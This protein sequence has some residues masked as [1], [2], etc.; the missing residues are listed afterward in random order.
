MKTLL[1][2]F[3]ATCSAFC[4][5]VAAEDIPKFYGIGEPGFAMAFRKEREADLRA[6]FRPGTEQFDIGI[7]E[8]RKGVRHVRPFSFDE[9]KHYWQMQAAGRFVLVTLD[10]NTLSDEDRT[11]LIKRLSDYLFKCG[12]RRVR[13]HQG[14]GSGVGVLFDRE[15]K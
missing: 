3:H 10:K 6:S 4:V 2:A 11:K 9:L 12:V 15:R 1:L 8:I 14:Y 13:I 5:T 7:G